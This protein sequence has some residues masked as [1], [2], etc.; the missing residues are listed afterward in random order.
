[1]AAQE[2]ADPAA[3]ALA[4]LGYAYGARDDARAGDERYYTLN[5]LADKTKG[6]EWKGQEDY[7]RVAVACAAYCKSRLEVHCRLA[8][9]AMG[10]AT[11]WASP[12]DAGPAAPLV[13]LVCGSNPGGSAGVWGRS[14]CVNATLGEGAMF[15][16]VARAARDLGGNVVVADPNV[17][18]DRGREIPGSECAHTHLCTL[19]DLAIPAASTR[20]VVIVAHSYGAAAVAYLF[21]AAPRARDRTKA[22]AFTDGCALCGSVLQELP[23][24]ESVPKL[25]AKMKP[26][27]AHAPRAF[28]A[29]A[30]A[31][32]ALRA[33]ARNFVA[34]EA[35]LGAPV[36]GGC[37]IDQVSAGH[38]AHP[39]TTAAATTAVFAFLAE[40]LKG[41]GA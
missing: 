33:V 27:L 41:E 12:G 15:D 14:L 34:S 4:A 8:P 32:A 16:Y 24:G 5:Q 31:A 9:V 1:M 38:T 17:S 7:D 30:A 22:V 19:W 10:E 25:A 35:P 18:E 13:F 3:R 21:K 29:D 28:E 2:Q 39:A 20:D 37:G 36:A 11:I 6:F 40:K 23:P 26:V